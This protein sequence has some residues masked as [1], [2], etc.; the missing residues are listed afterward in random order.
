MGDSSGLATELKPL[1]VIITFL[2]VFG[3]ITVSMPIELTVTPTSGHYTG[4][5][6]PEGIFDVSNFVTYGHTSDAINMTGTFTMEPEGFSFLF[7]VLGSRDYDC[8]A[9]VRMDSY[10]FGLIHILREAGK[11][12]NTN[13]TLL[14]ES[15]AWPSLWGKYYFGSGAKGD[16][17]SKEILDSEYYNGSIPIKFHVVFE[18][19][20]SIDVMFSFNTTKY[21]TPSL[22]WSQDELYMVVAAGFGGSAGGDI[23]TLIG[24]L[25][26]FQAPNM[27]PLLNAFIAI[28]I[29]SGIAYLIYV[30]LIKLK[31]DW[32]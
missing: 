29:W 1:V 19:Q 20:Q 11:W 14:S 17:I 15:R 21:E 32:L 12:Y 25:L 22:A 2:A 6:Y 18:T 10:I 31:P 24:Q 4:P 16:S 27:H 26:F 9:V 7:V 28:P 3:L 13:N 23:F 8:I 30:L 5:N